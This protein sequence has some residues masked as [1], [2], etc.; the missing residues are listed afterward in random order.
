VVED[1]E[2][3][4][5]GMVPGIVAAH[6]VNHQF[7]EVFRVVLPETDGAVERGFEAVPVIVVEEVSVALVVRFVRVI[8]VEDGVG[9]SAGVSYDGDS[10]V[11]Q[12]DELGEAAGF[13]FAGDEDDI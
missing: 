10:A 9:E 3:I 13:V 4:L 8:G 11:F 6:S 1:V 7:A 2:V 5:A 12:A